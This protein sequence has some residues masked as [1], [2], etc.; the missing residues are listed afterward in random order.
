MAVHETIPGVTRPFP[1]AWNLEHKGVV[2]GA[3]ILIALCLAGAVLVPG[4]LSGSNIRSILLL[5]AFLGLAA[6]GQ[7]FV[8]LLGGLDLSIP[9]VIGSANI[10]LAALLGAGVPALPAIVLIVLVGAGVGLLNALLSFSL[11]NQALIV[12]LGVGFTLV[13]LS[14]VLTS[15]GNAYGGN[16]MGAVPALLAHISAANGTTFGLPV[17]PVVLIWVCATIAVSF[18]MRRSR[19]GRGFYA[20]GGNRIAAAR[21]SISAFR[22][23][24][25]AYCLSGALAA[26]TGILLLGFSGG[27]FVG[28][29]DSYLFTTIAAVVLGGTSLL[30]GAGGSTQTV[31]G[32]LVLQVL[33]SLLVGL[34][35]SFAAQQVVFGLMIVPMVAIYARSPEI[36]LQI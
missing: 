3:A 22:Y 16:V 6:M 4:F 20:V 32:V 23:W 13:G 19:I 34:G 14:Q 31:I 11:Q 10:G 29:G 9:F 24:I 26:T 5:A 33:T 28:V 1:L 12:S 21:L 35:F 27:G 18:L 2:F 17:P 15:I 7:T 8:A 25:Y 36:R 30:G